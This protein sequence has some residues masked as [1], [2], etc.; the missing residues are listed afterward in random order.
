MSKE[1][2]VLEH[3][4]FI[5]N[6]EIDEEHTTLNMVYVCKQSLDIIETVLNEKVNIENRLDEIFENH[7]I[8]SFTE[9]NERLCDYNELKFDDEV[10]QKKLKAF[11]IIKSFANYKIVEVQGQWYLIQGVSFDKSPKIPITETQAI[12]LSEALS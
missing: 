6:Y 4:E 8:K 3:L 7:N 10:K 12:L 9:L 1:L 5:R 11:E 2:D